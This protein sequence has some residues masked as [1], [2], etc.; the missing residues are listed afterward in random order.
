[1]RYDV[2][3]ISA[4]LLCLLVV[5]SMGIWMGIARDFTLS[6]VHAHVNLLGWV[7]LAA[8]GLIHR[9]YPSLGASRLAGTQCALAVAS[10]VAMP[11]GIALAMLAHNPVVAIAAAFGVLTATL[12]FAAMFVRR[13]TTS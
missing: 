3:F 1:M 7:T 9:V 4:A 6:P 11:A 13:A 2:I 5:E 8:Y 10:S 12:M